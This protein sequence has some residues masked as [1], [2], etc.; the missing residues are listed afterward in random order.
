ME[1]KS[2]Y[3]L[4]AGPKHRVDF[5][6]A[7]STL[8]H[9]GNK[10]QVFEIDPFRNPLSEGELMS[11]TDFP[12]EYSIHESRKKLLLVPGTREHPLNDEI[13]GVTSE[14][15]LYLHTHPSSKFGE[16]NNFL[17]MADVFVARVYGENTQLMLITQKGI[18]VYRR[19]QYDPVRK[20]STNETARELMSVWGRKHNIDFFASN[21]APGDKDFFN[22]PNKE[23]EKIVRQFCDETKMITAEVAWGEPGM[24]RIVDSINLRLKISD[25]SAPKPPS[26]IDAFPIKVSNLRINTPQRS[27]LEAAIQ[28]LDLINNRIGR[29]YDNRDM[30]ISWKA[31][32]FELL[33][34]VREE[35]KVDAKTDLFLRKVEE[36]GKMVSVE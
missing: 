26:I 9:E 17:S 29:L 22:L 32:A 13:L 10:H 19:P 1:N 31:F 5:A 35:G 28:H 4:E 18:V 27:S 15:Q 7:M 16:P 36:I 34:Q 21:R 2:T 14:A 30:R 20:I 23:Q 33:Q 3:G 6:V 11:L 12:W 25:N 8:H 24:Q